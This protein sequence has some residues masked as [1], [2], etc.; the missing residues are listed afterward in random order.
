ML[1]FH[2]DHPRVWNWVLYRHRNPLSW[3]TFLD[4][5]TTSKNGTEDAS[6]RFLFSVSRFRGEP[7]MPF[8]P[9]R[10]ELLRPVPCSMR[11]SRFLRSV[12]KSTC[13]TIVFSLLNLVT[14]Q[15]NID[16]IEVTDATACFFFI[17]KVLVK[18]EL[19]CCW[20]DT[21]RWIAG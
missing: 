21:R 13:Q 18:L 11:P 19:L 7:R 1:S 15:A 2:G 3:S 5:R 9:V 8:S 10:F 20:N 14:H 4:S 6:S 17:F 12:L 16:Y